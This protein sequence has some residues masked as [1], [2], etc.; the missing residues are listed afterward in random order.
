MCVIGVDVQAGRSQHCIEL[1]RAAQVVAQAAAAKHAVGVELE[2]SA[3]LLTLEHVFHHAVGEGG[4]FVGHVDRGGAGAIAETGD[5]AAEGDV[6]TGG[7]ADGGDVDFSAADLKAPVAD[8]AH[9]CKLGVGNLELVRSSC[10]AVVGDVNS[11]T[12]SGGGNLQRTGVSGVANDE[13]GGAG[14]KTSGQSAGAG[15]AGLAVDDAELDGIA[16]LEVEVGLNGDG[17]GSGVDTGFAERS[18]GSSGFV[19]EGAGR[20][21]QNGGGHWLTRD[22]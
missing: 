8:L 3:S 18:G 6:L 14:R 17:V 2:G 15:T 7:L 5:V 13:V 10:G 19:V 4:V 1:D 22:D 12:A 20:A 9:N 16:N 21:G 11:R